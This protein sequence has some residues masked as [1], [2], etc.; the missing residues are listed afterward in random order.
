MAT[1]TR[2]GFLA[3]PMKSPWLDH[4]ARSTSGLIMASAH[5][6]RENNRYGMVRDLISEQDEINKRRSKA[7]HL[8]LVSNRSS[9]RTARSRDIDGSSAT[10]GL[11]GRMGW[12]SST[13]A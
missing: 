11:R 8:P 10:R 9:W 3:E 7:P 4:K 6:D 13:P 12:S 5:T 2:V 1:L